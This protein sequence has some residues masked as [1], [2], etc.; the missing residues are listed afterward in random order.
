[1]EAYLRFLWKPGNIERRL[2]EG[3]QHVVALTEEE[4]IQR[5]L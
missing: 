2:R 4:K 3:L 5:V 1:V